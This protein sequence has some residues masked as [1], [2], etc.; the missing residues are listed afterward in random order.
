MAD[1]GHD[2]RRPINDLDGDTQ[3]TVPFSSPA[4]TSTPPP[5][6]P[7]PPAAAKEASLQS[8]SSSSSSS[9]GTRA[10]SSNIHRTW[11]TSIDVPQAKAVAQWDQPRPGRLPG[12]SFD[13]HWHLSSSK[14]FFR[15][16]A[17]DISKGV[18]RKFAYKVCVLERKRIIEA[19]VFNGL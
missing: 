7:P 15:L 12:L 10:Q 2:G 17:W 4:S 3:S 11:P 1:R 9:P 8:S 5:P 18:E 6:P 14:A 19:F 13:L 16:H